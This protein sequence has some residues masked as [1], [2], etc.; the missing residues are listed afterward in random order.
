MPPGQEGENIELYRNLSVM[1]FLLL[2]FEVR[3]SKYAAT[4]EYEN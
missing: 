1:V 4:K 2:V 3:H